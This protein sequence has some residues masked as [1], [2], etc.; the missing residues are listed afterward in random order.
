LIGENLGTHRFQRAVLVGGV[1]ENQCAASKDCT[2][3]AMRTQASPDL[4]AGFKSL[5]HSTS[6]CTLQL[7]ATTPPQSHRRQEAVHKPPNAGSKGFGSW[8]N[9][10]VMKRSVFSANLRWNA[11]GARNWGFHDISQT[12]YLSSTSSFF[13]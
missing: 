8:R 3:E 4:C 7:V 12:T 6:I 10:L 9:N 11:Y 13:S 1:F 5:M 2:L